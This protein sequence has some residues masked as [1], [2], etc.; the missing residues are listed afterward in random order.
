MNQTGFRGDVGESAVAV[1]FEKMRSWFLP[2]G[3]TFEAPAVHEKNILPTVVVV[4]V[5]GDAAGGGFEKISVF[6]FAAEKGFG[7]EARFARDVE[8]SDTQIVRR[9]SR[10]IENIPRG[11]RCGVPPAWPRE[12]KDP[13]QWQYYRRTTKRFKKGS[14]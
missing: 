12:R 1:I 9:R 8:E 4:I 11:R 5:E 10:R 7:V 14:P 13:V 3:K 2:R 6:V